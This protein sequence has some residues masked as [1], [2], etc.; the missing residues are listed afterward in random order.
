MAARIIR[1]NR[2]SKRAVRNRRGSSDG[3]VLRCE[4][5]EDRRMLAVITV[6]TADDVVDLTDGRT[7]LREAIFAANTVPG[8]DEIVFDLG[9]NDTATIVLTEGQIVISDPLSLVGP[10]AD[11][12]T[13]DASGS[14]P[15]PEENNGDGSRIF[16][17]TSGRRPPIDVSISGVTLTG[18]DTPGEGGAIQSFTNLVLSNVRIIENYAGLDGGG[19]VLGVSADLSDVHLEDNA[20][21][22]NGGAIRVFSGAEVSIE[23]STIVGNEAGGGGGGLWS[24]RGATTTIVSSDVRQNLAAG[25]GGGLGLRN[26]TSTIID[27]RIDGNSGLVGGGIYSRGGTLDFQESSLSFNGASQ[28]G[29]G[30]RLHDMQA[31]ITDSEIRS[32]G[33]VNFDGTQ[34]MGISQSGGELTIRNSALLGNLGRAQETS[35]GAIWVEDG[36]LYI[37]GSQLNENNVTSRGGA[38]LANN[39]NV[40]IRDTT[41]SR[42]NNTNVVSGGAIWAAGSSVTIEQSEVSSNFANVNGGAIYLTGSNAVVTDVHFENNE[43]REGSGGAIWMQPAQ[44]SWALTITDSVFANNR[45]SLHGGAIGSDASGTIEVQRSLF[46]DNQTQNGRGGAIYSERFTDLSVSESA[47]VRNR[48]GADGGAIYS[49]FELTVTRSVI[50]NNDADL[51]GG[52]IYSSSLG[53]G[54]APVLIEE[55]TIAENSAGVQGGGV[56]ALA[57]GSMIEIVNSTISQN[58]AVEAGGGIYFAGRGRTTGIYNIRHSTIAFNEDSS[59]QAGAGVVVTGSDLLIDHT[60]VYGNQSGGTIVDVAGVQGG[61]ID[62]HFSMLGTVRPGTV[63]SA[64][65]LTLGVDPQLEPLGSARV[66]L[67]IPLGQFPIPLHALG[68][69]SAALDAGDP[70]LRPGVDG[71]PEFDQRGAPFSRVVPASPRSDTSVIDIGAYEEQPSQNGSLNGDFDD[72]RRVAGNDFLI[73]QRNFGRQ[74]NA[75]KSDGDATG[76][77]DVDHN[78]LATW[79]ATYGSV[80]DQPP[81]RLVAAEPSAPT[82]PAIDIALEEAI[83]LAGRDYR[84]NPRPGYEEIIAQNEAEQLLVALADRVFEEL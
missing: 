42:N 3:R 43:S 45:A 46:Q 1:S 74:E 11:V 65:N 23:D 22:G 36:T 52:G 8:H 54:S 27:T 70:A 51:N 33:I 24:T 71:T 78:D 41:I 84:P 62:V 34:G 49:V 20:S 30:L 61:T 67:P 63:L 48:S 80:V 18:A 58:L 77:G 12:L 13:I 4:S 21:G 73:W 39:A 40:H 76:D 17:T 66:I 6:D 35:G 7:S 72:N 37:E 50:M 79:I 60:I 14:D 2:R 55:S 56:Y 38:I 5:L 75:T 15:T 59:Q 82:E 16:F 47:L 68:S 28:T 9:G 29:A 83:Y 10:G 26:D 57:S 19:L 81:R 69:F 25:F 64:T 53:R 44:S 32:N 31:E